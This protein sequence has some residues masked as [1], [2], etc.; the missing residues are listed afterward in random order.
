MLVIEVD[1]VEPGALQARVAGGADIVGPAV[2]ALEA[3][4]FAANVA[5]LGRDDHPLAPLAHDTADQFLVRADAVHVGGVEEGDA[6]V[7][8]AVD[9]RDRLCL[10]AD[11]VEIGHAHAAETEGG[12]FEALLAEFAGLHRI[13]PC[14]PARRRRGGERRPGGVP[15]RRRAGAPPTPCYRLECSAPVSVGIA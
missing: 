7:E 4:V 8:R 11:A 3:A 12:D 15:P 2:D 6:E 5:E 1:H 9:R 13:S 14:W 10:V